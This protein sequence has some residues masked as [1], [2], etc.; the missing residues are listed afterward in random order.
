MPSSVPSVAIRRARPDEL[1]AVGQLTVDA[2]VSGGVIPAD[3]PYLDFLG[4]AH[5]R[6]ADAEVW[7]AVDARG[8][9]GR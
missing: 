7:V 6:D 8:V 4:D 3:A 1:D 9:V 2:Y 5:S